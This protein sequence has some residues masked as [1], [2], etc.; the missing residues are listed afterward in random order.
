[1]YLRLS[2]EDEKAIENGLDKDESNSI[3]SQRYLIKEYIRRTTEFDD[4]QIKEYCDDGYSGTSLDRPDIQKLLEEVKK[5]RINCIIVKDLSRFARDYIELGTYMNQI[6][7]FM[8]VRFIAINDHYDSAKHKG[9]T[10]EIDTAFK[11]LL[12]DLYSKDISEK[13][14]AS[15]KNKLDKGEYVFGQTPFGYGKDANQ[16]NKL[17]VNEEEAIIVRYIFE[18]S[19]DGNSPVA[20]AKR[21]Y[22][23]GIPTINQMRRP[24]KI[25]KNRIVIWNE[26]GIRKML[27]NRF[28]LGEFAYGKSR[29]DVGGKNKKDIPP[30]EWSVIKNHHTALV[31]EED[32][33]NTTI[34]HVGKRKKSNREKNPLVGKMVCGGCRYPMIYKPETNS[35]RT[36]RFEC[37]THAKL[38]IK[39]CCTFFNGVVLEEIILK[40]LNQQILFMGDLT[41][42]RESLMEAQKAIMSKLKEQLRSAK[43]D[44]KKLVRAKDKEYEKYAAGYM[45]SE[46]YMQLSKEREKKL[47][48]LDAKIE[49]L[50]DKLNQIEEEYYKGADDLKQ[51]IRYS[52]IE[53]LTQEIVDTFIKS[54]YLYHDKRIEIEWQFADNFGIGV[55]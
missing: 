37:R 44:K 48:A 29:S 26:S 47:T 49:S 53:K 30:E 21:L 54:I 40:E 7:P 24:E 14:K 2:I 34:V 46:R 5:G 39:D 31:S 38:H 55:D 33:V 11:T 36:P 28:Y 3:T 17:V 20:I 52:H 13:V 12:Y 25:R 10:V 43:D 27:T 15:F 1:M 51:V 32:F 42:E 45:T 4:F 50:N 8:G 18:L 9:T 16:K 19:V 6:F 22:E 35:N 41:K 23:E